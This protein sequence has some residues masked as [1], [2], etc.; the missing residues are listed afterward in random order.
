[1]CLFH[2]CGPHLLCDCVV[3]F[4]GTARDRVGTVY[5]FVGTARDRRFRVSNSKSL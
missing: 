3:F 2:S 5:F 1:M 4:V